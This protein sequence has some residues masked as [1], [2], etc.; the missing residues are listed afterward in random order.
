MKTQISSKLEF[1]SA[2]SE[3]TFNKILKFHPKFTPKKK[4]KSLHIWCVVSE[5]KAG[6]SITIDDLR[7]FADTLSKKLDM[8]FSVYLDDKQVS[9]AT[10]WDSRFLGASKFFD[11]SVFQASY[12]LGISQSVECVLK[13]AFS[14]D[15]LLNLDKYEELEPLP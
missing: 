6:T 8:P 4:N 11:S 10:F 2:E 12:D 9:L 5:I 1:Y 14:V 15:E 7:P 13:T 3:A